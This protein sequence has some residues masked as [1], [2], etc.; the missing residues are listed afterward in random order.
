M[1]QNKTGKAKL[2][3]FVSWQNNVKTKKKKKKQPGMTDICCF[4][5]NGS[6]R[7]SV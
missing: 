7:I 3:C 5:F 1:L 4:G 2:H 6:F